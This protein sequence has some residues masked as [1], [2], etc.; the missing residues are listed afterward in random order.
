M[1]TYVMTTGA[2][3]GLITL[4]HI[5]R[6]IAEGPRLAK[7]PAKALT[8]LEMTKTVRASIWGDVSSSTEKLAEDRKA[9]QREHLSILINLAQADGSASALARGDLEAIS[10]RARQALAAGT[11]DEAT[12][13]H[14]KA[15]LAKIKAALS[16]K[17]G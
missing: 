16:A 5:L 12:R 6:I 17:V 13:L 2:V 7:D 9:L 1:K 3:F 4:A 14:L 8:P 10:A 11:A 15:V